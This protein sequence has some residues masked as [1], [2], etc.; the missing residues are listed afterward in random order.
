MIL[1]NI[2]RLYSIVITPPFPIIRK[3]P[4]VMDNDIRDAIFNDAAE[5]EELDDDFVVQAAEDCGGEQEDVF[6]YDAHIAELIRRSERQTGVTVRLEGDAAGSEE[7]SER[8]SDLE[9]LDATLRE[10]DND[11]LGALE[12]PEDDPTMQGHILLED[13]NLEDIMDSF[14]EE[15]ARIRTE[16]LPV[17]AGMGAPD[18]KQL[19]EEKKQKKPKS[20]MTE[21][22]KYAASDVEESD[23]EEEEGGGGDSEEDEAGD[24]L[25]A[26]A[27]TVPEYADKPRGGDEAW[28]CESILSTL[29]NLENHPTH[30]MEPK[31]KGSKARSTNADTASERGGHDN[32][33]HRIVL[34]TKTG[35]PILK[36]STGEEEK[37]AGI[38]GGENKGVGRNKKETKEEKKA[39]KQAIKKERQENRTQKRNL[40]DAYKADEAQQR[41]VGGKS[42]TGISTFRYS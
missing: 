24:V 28:D 2:T 39:R 16:H 15:T 29:S 14:L 35:V 3:W 1:W 6:D 40:K 10:Y 23:L 5:F 18:K 31:R 37:K 4:A 41:V 21:A 32:L 12:D 22:E 42:G 17:G 19:L 9:E 8:P 13:E 36:P 33:P 34:S 7:E 11:E 30:L 25:G 27:F 26:D 38:G 20:E